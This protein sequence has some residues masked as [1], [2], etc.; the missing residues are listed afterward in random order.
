MFEK[1]VEGDEFYC[2]PVICKCS[3]RKPQ[4]EVDIPCFML[5]RARKRHFH[6]QYHQK[7]FTM[8]ILRANLVCHRCTSCPD[9]NYQSLDILSN[10]WYYLGIGLHPFSYEVPSHDVENDQDLTNDDADLVFQK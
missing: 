10:S 6:L 9:C 7:L 4:R 8:K 3:V 5:I 1:W 2:L